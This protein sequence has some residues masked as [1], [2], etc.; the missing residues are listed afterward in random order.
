MDDLNRTC[1][2]YIYHICTIYMSYIILIDRLYISS[3]ISMGKPMAN[4]Q[5]LKRKKTKSLPA[6]PEMCWED[7]ER[8]VLRYPLGWAN[9]VLGFLM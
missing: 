7:F 5:C 2:I 9:V 1:K 8:L 4:R 6:L 3:I